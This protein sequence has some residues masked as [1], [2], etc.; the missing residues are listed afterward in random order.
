MFW[1]DLRYSIRVLTKNPGFAAVAVLTL[2][3]GIGANTAM[4]SVMNTLFL[5]PPGITDPG[6]LLAIRVKYEKLNLGNIGV[7]LTDYADARNSKDVFSSVAAVQPTSANYLGATLPE[8]LTGE[9]VTWNFFDTLG[10][11]PLLGRAFHPEEDQPGG[12]HEVMLSYATWKRLFGGDPAIVDKT[13]QLN[14]ENY[15]VIG[16]M[17]ADFD[18]PAGA[19]V[20]IPLGLP[21]SEYGPENRF[22]ESYTAVGRVQAGVGVSQAQAFMNVLTE[23]VKRSGTQDGAYAKD[24]LWGMF[25]I[26]LMN[27]VYGELRTPMLVLLGAVGFVL[28]ITCAN[29]AGLMLARASGRSRELAVRSALGAGQWHLVQQVLAESVVLAGLGTIVGLGLSYAAIRGLQIIAPDQTIRALSV[30]LDRYVLLFSVLVGAASALLF[31]IAPA[32]QT[33]GVANF[34]RLKEGGRSGTSSRGRQRV[35]SALVVGEVSLALVLLIG[36]GLLLKSL[37]R[38]Q[39]FSPGFD[40]QGVMTA[41]VSLSPTTYS[42]DNKQIAFYTAVTQRL[43]NQPGV[44]AAGAALGMPFTSFGPSSSFSI[45]GRPEGPGDPG[46]HSD[47]ASV[48]P[49]Y[50]SALKI[51]LLSG[52]VF[53]DSDRLNT[54]PVV[55]IDDN[56]ARQ[57]WPNENPIG[58]HLRRGNRTQWSE[59]IGVVAHV[60][61]SSLAADT[62]KGICY[63]SLFQIAMPTVNLV[64]RTSADPSTLTAAMRDAVA[65]V[66]PSQAAVYDF[67]P[68]AE[69]VST[70][71]GPRRFA[72]TL[73]G[74]FAA[75]ALL[76]ASLGLYGIISYGV[77]Q[78]TQEIGI[79][80]ALGA[81]R[82]QVLGMVIGQGMLLVGIGGAIGFVAAFLLTRLI[83]SQLVQTSAFDPLTFFATAL[84]LAVVTLLATYLPARRAAKVDPMVALRYE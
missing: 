63:Y 3:L 5:H 82:S 18:W 75:F 45:E 78:R 80:M 61:R 73:L 43:A 22:N 34:E 48:T 7:S 84:V 14:Q 40:S 1:R 25:A 29:L 64:A 2:A 28:L 33:A 67:Q 36:A 20:W 52:R 37:A 15:K 31:G 23:R 76:L 10:S 68:L 16:V 65:A 72:V 81:Q 71:L 53:T 35:R 24:A 79:R 49:G 27:L 9:L 21:A 59:I 47:L 19:Q 30:Q 12:E 83:A 44:I 50:F 70:S 55:V 74:I 17:G 56:L 42:D 38:L 46:P 39:Q 51:P 77:A 54:Q 6:R 57:Y 11:K 4:F 58:K 26:P 32:W 41:A 62:G 13:I 8:R 66:D 60:K 69:R